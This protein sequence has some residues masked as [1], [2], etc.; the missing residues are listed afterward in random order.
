MSEARFGVWR[1]PGCGGALQALRD[2]V[3]SDVAERFAPPS[4]GDRVPPV[5]VCE[6]CF[7]AWFDWWAG[8]SCAISTQLADLPRAQNQAR[9]GEGVCPR[10]ATPLSSQAY[11]GT[12]PSVRRCARCLGLFAS[13]AQVDELAAFAHQLPESP[14]PIE[15]PNLLA[16]IWRLWA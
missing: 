10:D 9:R 8:E 3:L 14:D 4:A 7:G 1:C 11:M 16:R 5:S 2:D 13:R 12:G 15:Y 6:A